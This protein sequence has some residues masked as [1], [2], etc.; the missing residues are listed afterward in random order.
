MSPSEGLRQHGES[1][2]PTPIGWPLAP[3]PETGVPDR[4]RAR[5]PEAERFWRDD[6]SRDYSGLPPAVQ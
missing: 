5:Q 1:A 2:T 6:G 4:L 3:A